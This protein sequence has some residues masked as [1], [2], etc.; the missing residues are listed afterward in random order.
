MSRLARLSR[1]LDPT[2]LIAAACL[3]DRTR[4]AIADGLAAELDVIGLNEYFG[5]YEPSFEGLRRL[6]ANSDPSKPVIVTEFGAD[7]VAGL[8]GGERE[9]FT[10]D[11]Q[12]ALYREQL[13]ILATA[14]PT[15]A[16]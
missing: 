16:G 9:L 1:A 6:L 3:I 11:C 2:R 13:A 12:A 10:E 14:P 7:A 5:W 15:C 8:R 4:F